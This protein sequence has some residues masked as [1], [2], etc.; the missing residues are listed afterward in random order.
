MQ[1]PKLTSIVFSFDKHEV[2]WHPEGKGE[3]AGRTYSMIYKVTVCPGNHTFRTSY[4][5]N[6]TNSLQFINDCYAALEDFQ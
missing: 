4:N 6:K 5:A 2:I 1:T 3:I